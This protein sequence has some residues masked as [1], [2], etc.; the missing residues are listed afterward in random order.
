FVGVEALIRWNH[1]KLGRVSPDKFIPLAEQTGLI[2]PLTVWV[3]TEALRQSYVWRR[4]GLEMNVAVNVSAKNLH[5]SDLA[6]HLARLLSASGASAEKLIVEVTESAIMGDESRAQNTLNKL[7][8]QG[9][10]IAIDDFGTGYSSFANLRS[11][12]VTEIKIDKSFV[13]GMAKSNEDRIIVDSIIELGHK[14][15]MHVVAEG[16]E[17]LAA[18]SALSELHCDLA[19]GYYLSRPLPADDLLGWT[20]AFVP[21]TASATSATKWSDAV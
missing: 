16:I 9:A 11:L 2:N 12:P 18:W 20:R 7:H 10:E 3:L 1:P 14:L 19:Q 4:V 13:I 15:G 17:T 6:E 21:P 5:S 8:A